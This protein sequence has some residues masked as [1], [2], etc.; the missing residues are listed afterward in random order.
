MVKRRVTNVG[1]PNS[2]YTVKV[3]EPEGVKV[4][5]RPRRLSFSRLNQRLSYRVWFIS[6]K[7]TGSRRGRFG[8]GQLTWMNVKDNGI[9]IRSPILVTRSS[10][11]QG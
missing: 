8:Q 4:R 6:R 3:V 5:V 11:K 1:E 9:K 10:S 7:S 2:V